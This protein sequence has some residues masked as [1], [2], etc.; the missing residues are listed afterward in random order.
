MT[1]PFEDA[2]LLVERAKAQINDLQA[3]IHSFTSPK[4]Y[5]IL[6]KKNPKTGYV[7]WIV[8]ATKPVPSG[9]SLTAKDILQNLRSPLDYAVCA[10]V[11]QAGQDTSRVMF[12]FGKTKKA[13]KDEIKRRKIHLIPDLADIIWAVKPYQRGNKM[14]FALHDLNR[15]AKHRKLTAVAMPAAKMQFQFSSHCCPVN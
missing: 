4:P 8:R 15:H 5:E 11:E 9:I 13:L 2:K 12:P 1:N 10:V 7:T 6:A 3:A 14:L